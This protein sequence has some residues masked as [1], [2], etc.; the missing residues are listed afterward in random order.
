MLEASSIGHVESKIT[1]LIQTHLEK[2]IYDS[3]SVSYK[4]FLVG[5]VCG[6]TKILVGEHFDFD[7]E[8][9]NFSRPPI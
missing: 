8:L 6:V 3:N 7:F 9:I 4:A 2:P 1:S 5:L